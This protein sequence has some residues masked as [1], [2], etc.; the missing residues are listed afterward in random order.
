MV[1]TIPASGTMTAPDRTGARVSRKAQ[2]K[3]DLINHIIN[4]E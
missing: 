2:R 4:I 1:D 3:I